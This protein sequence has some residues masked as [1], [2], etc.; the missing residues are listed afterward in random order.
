MAAYIQPYTC[1]IGDSLTIGSS[2]VDLYDN[3]RDD[4]F[5]S[6]TPGALWNESTDGEYALA[7]SNGL[8]IE[9]N[10]DS[11]DA[12]YKLESV[13][14]YSN[15]DVTLEYRIDSAYMSDV[16]QSADG[17][18][19]ARLRAEGSGVSFGISRRLIQDIGHCLY[20][21]YNDGVNAY[22]GA[23]P[24]ASSS[25]ILR[26]VKFGTS[27]AWYHNDILMKRFT[28]AANVAMNVT[29]SSE[30]YEDDITRVTF[31]KYESN[32]CV[33]IADTFC[34][35]QIESDRRIIVTTPTVMLEG[36]YQISVFNHD[37]VLEVASPG[38]KIVK[39]PGV[40]LGSATTFVVEN[41]AT[42]RY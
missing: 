4:S 14:T 24:D 22:G 29:I 33:N 35:A 15:F 19:Y 1:S 27:Y 11:G 17:V 31:V 40:A 10:P 32:T 36:L 8:S 2:T 39:P 12:F 18:W 23:I 5:P 21:E 13:D 30:L 6:T 9:L 41:D 7:I 34:V 42:L 28:L 20:V 38:V 3:S 37:G 26:I 25:G 16:V